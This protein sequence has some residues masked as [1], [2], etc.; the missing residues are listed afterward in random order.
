MLRQISMRSRFLNKKILYSNILHT[1]NVNFINIC[2]RHSMG[3]SESSNSKCAGCFGSQAV[4]PS[5]SRLNKSKAPMIS[6]QQF[7]NGNIHK[8]SPPKPQV[9]EKPQKPQH[10]ALSYTPKEKPPHDYKRQLSSTPNFQKQRVS[11][12]DFDTV[13]IIGKGTFGKVYLVRKR[14]D[15]KYY[16]LKVLKKSDIVV[17]NTTEYVLAEKHILQNSYHPF[18]VR[19]RYAFQ[20]ELKLYFVM[21]YISGGDLFTQLKR[22]SRFNEQTASFF[23][24]EVVLALQYLHDKMGVLYRDL[25]P[26]NILLGGDGHIRIT[27]FGLAKA[28]RKRQ[29]SFCGTPEYIAPE[30]LMKSGHSFNVDW[31]CLGCLIYEML[32]GHPPFQNNNK[33]ILY[34]EILNRNPHMPSYLSQKAIDIIMRLLDKN[35]NER[36]GCNGVE[37]IKEH[38]FFENIRWDQMILKKVRPPFLPL[39]TQPDESKILDTLDSGI[40][41]PSED[42]SIKEKSPRIKKNVAFSH[43]DKVNEHI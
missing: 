34:D 12:D 41:D 30:I 26:E 36:L 22:K 14:S 29:Y 21:D 11:I 13:R 4:D 19:L 38:P 18:I 10:F 9:K 32:V 31:W 24:A 25:K 37:E 27:D 3:T 33:A 35:P 7:F 39:Q 43:E 2:F 1:I 40:D 17:K 6:P 8:E 20:D 42:Y 28:S 5:K 15:Q 23:A 16:A